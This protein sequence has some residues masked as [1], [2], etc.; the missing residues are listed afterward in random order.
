MSATIGFDLDALS[1]AIEGRDA[2]YLSSMYA[3]NAEM[4]EIDNDH[5]P[6]RPRM[7]HGRSEI[8]E[9]LR[10][11]CAR[12]MTHRMENPVLADGRLAYTEACRYDDGT[13]VY[14]MSTAYLDSSNR[15]AR[16]VGVTAWGS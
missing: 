6:A 14:S 13:E 11:V 5:P 16:Q 8:A 10:D 1:R 7:F 3:D 4:I 12:Q 15:I 9:H 2:E